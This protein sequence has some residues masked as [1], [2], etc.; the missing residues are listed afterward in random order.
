LAV[1][2]GAKMAGAG[3]II[4]VD[5]NSE[6]FKM[7]KQLG[8]T[9]FVNSK[10]LDVPVQQHIVGN[11]TKWGVDYTFDCTGNVQVMRTAL[12]CSH[13]GWGTCL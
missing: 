6:K 13:R 5:I 7:A 11:L 4:A 10:E 1:I 2:Q 8:A 9:D 12:E 3:R